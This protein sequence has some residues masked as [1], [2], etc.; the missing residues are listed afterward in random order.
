MTPIAQAHILLPFCLEKR[1]KQK[2]CGSRKQHLCC[3][4]STEASSA[5]RASAPGS[6][7]RCRVHHGVGNTGIAQWHDR[8]GSLAILG[9]SI[10]SR[11]STI[12]CSAASFPAFPTSHKLQRML[13]S[14]VV[15]GE[16]V[17]QRS[18]DG[19]MEEKWGGG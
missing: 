4:W 16:A 10:L 3:E 11:Q 19:F 17:F 9:K 2:S 8:L 6:H 1:Q 5:R 7:A 12:K 15:T 13:R 18:T 14:S